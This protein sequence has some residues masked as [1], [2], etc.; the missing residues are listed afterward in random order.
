M[1]ILM[2]SARLWLVNK[3]IVIFL[4]VPACLLPNQTRASFFFGTHVRPEVSRYTPK[5]ADKLVT[6][7][8]KELINKLI[9]NRSTC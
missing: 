2:L 1:I 6:K 7:L 9:N 4:L 8:V 5:S 3:L